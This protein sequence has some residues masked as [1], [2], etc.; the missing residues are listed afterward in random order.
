[1]SS[2]A[3]RGDKAQKDLDNT[4]LIAPFDG[5]VAALNIQ[6]GDLARG[7][8]DIVDRGVVL[9]TPDRVMLNL[10]ISETDYGS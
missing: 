10:T 1:M 4:K 5:T 7:H 2:G 9:N 6:V 3:E 8:G